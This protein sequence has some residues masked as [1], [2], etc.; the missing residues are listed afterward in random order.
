MIEL[1]VGK[2]SQTSTN[3]AVTFIDNELLVGANSET[4]NNTDVTFICNELHV[5]A[6]CKPNNKTHFSN[7]IR[8][9]YTLYSRNIIKCRNL[10]CEF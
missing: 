4:S 9:K 7:H 10:Y 6:V 3:I 8:T 5:G 1:F 2:D